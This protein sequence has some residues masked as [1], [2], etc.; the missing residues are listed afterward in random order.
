MFNT[1]TFFACLLKE[2]EFETGDPLIYGKGERIN[3]IYIVSSQTSLLLNITQWRLQILFPQQAPQV[4]LFFIA[5]FEQD[6]SLKG[7][8]SLLSRFL[9]SSLLLFQSNQDNT[10]TE[11]SQVFSSIP[12]SAFFQRSQLDSR[13]IFCLEETKNL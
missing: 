5:S 2:C 4:Q 1:F 13:H 10:T 6:V 3:F 7:Q 12:R 11:S 9:T 8:L